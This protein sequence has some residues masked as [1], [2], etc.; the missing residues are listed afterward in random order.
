[1]KPTHYGQIAAVIFAAEAA[2]AVTHRI[3]G[4]EYG[5]FTHTFNVSVDLVL[6][7]IW[8]TAAVAVTVRRTFAAFLAVLIGGLATHIHGILFSVASPGTGA[9]VPFLLASCILPLL[10][11]RSAP[12]WSAA[13]KEAE[14]RRMHPTSMQRSSHA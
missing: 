11:V 8:L 12:A 6:A 9:G 14:E 1:M 5:R 3:V 2:F 7:A 4:G 10:A 13:S